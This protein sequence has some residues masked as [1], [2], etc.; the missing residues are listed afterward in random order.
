MVAVYLVGAGVL[1]I[2]VLAMPWLQR[3]HPRIAPWLVP[4]MRLALS[5]PWL[6]PSR[7]DSVF[8]AVLFGALG[9]SVVQAYRKSKSPPQNRS[10]LPLLASMAFTALGFVA[11]VLIGFAVSQLL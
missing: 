10:K 11:A 8:T 1:V 4:P 7:W 5:I 9:F 2:I 6:A 3:A